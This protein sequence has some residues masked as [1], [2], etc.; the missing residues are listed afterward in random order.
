[1]LNTCGIC[2]MVPWLDACWHPS[3]NLVLVYS[4]FSSFPSSAYFD[5]PIS[6]FLSVCI[7]FTCMSLCDSK[8]PSL[9]FFFKYYGQIHCWYKLLYFQWFNL[10][11]KQSISLSLKDICHSFFL[12]AFPLLL[13]NLKMQTYTHKYVCMHV[14]ICAY[15]RVHT[16]IHTPFISTCWST[17]IFKRSLCHIAIYLFWLGLYVFSEN[18]LFTSYLHDFFFFF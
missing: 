14:C 15:I 10:T 1:M 4:D 16:Q 18:Y 8:L 9:L 13:V 6:W 17:D 11:S 12:L 7:V 3:L 5:S 2:V